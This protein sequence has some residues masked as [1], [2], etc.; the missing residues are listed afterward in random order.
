MKKTLYFLTLQLLIV[1]TLVS[2]V[3][4]TGGIKGFY[5]NNSDGFY[6]TVFTS[7][8]GLLSNLDTGII[9]S[10]ENGAAKIDVDA[11]VKSYSVN[12][13]M[14]NVGN[15]KYS[16][17]YLLTKDFNFELT[18]SLDAFGQ[19]STNSTVSLKDGFYM[20]MPDFAKKPFYYKGS[21]EEGV[22]QKI[23]NAVVKCF[24]E[25]SYVNGSESYTFHGVSIKADTTEICLNSDVTSEL[26]SLISDTVIETPN[27]ILN[28]FTNKALDLSYIVNGEKL[29]LT[30]KRYFEDNALCRESFKVH[31]NNG[32]YII[33]DIIA[34][35]FDKQ[36]NNVEISVKGFDGKGVFNIFTLAINAVNN[37]G[38][39]STNA[40]ALLGDE[41][42][43]EL[44][45]KGNKTGAKGKANVYFMTDIGE[46][47]LPV[48]YSCVTESEGTNKY[49]LK[50]DSIYLGF[51]IELV[52]TKN[53]TDR[54]PVLDEPDDYYD[55]SV[56]ENRYYYDEAKKYSDKEYSDIKALLSGE[57]PEPD[58]EKVEE[59]TVDPFKLDINYDYSVIYDTEGSYGKQ[60][61]DLLQSD[62]FSFTYSYHEQK[63]GYPV[64]T[65]TQYKADGK[66]MYKYNYADGTEY[67][68]LFSGTTRYEVR[69]DLKKIL[70]TE[71]S[72][73]D[74][75]IYYPEAV[76]KFYESGFCNYDNRELVY[77]RYYDYSNNK[78][79]F[80]FDENK[81]I[82]LMIIEDSATKEEMYTFVDSI[83]ET[84]PENVMQL[85]SYEYE[86]V[87]DHFQ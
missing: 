23:K 35:T 69:H 22:F 81:E 49:T 84:V 65:C 63:E 33:L 31:D 46:A 78:Y 14:L 85:P 72:E 18:T 42:H 11:T 10:F 59:P 4:F 32:H 66:N 70:F 21:Q 82:E 48:S 57:T 52:V 51:D 80:V 44:E 25:G 71:Y 37:E 62:N 54:T 53:A 7:L 30:W 41:I 29:H 60:Y 9:P 83:S 67:I 17:H 76:Y 38:E 75:K 12:D 87:L 6:K 61:V 16:A 68:Q 24:K 34:Q 74:F 64:N 28:S 3:A 43:L 13:K 47:V 2:C 5:N 20:N 86:S 45:N 56:L 79:T 1:L 77:E 39:Y 50:A 40:D 8:N 19:K 55:I 26:V 58:E 73:E 27:L 15:G 36:T